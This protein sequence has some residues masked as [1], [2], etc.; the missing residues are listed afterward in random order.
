MRV[1]ILNLIVNT[2]EKGRIP[3]YDSNHD[4]MIYNM[5]R[6]FVELGH[7]V[8]LIADKAFAPL[9]EESNPFETIYLPGYA[10]CIFRPDM[11]PAPKG[12]KAYLKN[13]A[14][15]FD[16]VVS[17]ELFSMA[18]LIASRVP[19]I[20]NKL[21]VW[22]ELSV[23]Q[24]FMRQLPARFWYKVITPVL[25]GS[26]IPVIARSLPAR[27]F[28]SQFSRKVADDIVDHGV[29]AEVFVDRKVGASKSFVVVSQL[30]SRK[31][32]DRII[33]KFAR[34]LQV[35]GYQ[36]CRLD[37]IGAGDEMDNLKTLTNNLGVEHEVVFHGRLPQVQWAPISGNAVAMLIDTERDLNMVTVS[38]SIVNITPVLMNTVPATASF[39]AD[40]QLGIAREDWDIPEMIE[41][42]ERQNEF[43][44]NCRAVRES[45]TASGSAKS[46]IDIFTNRLF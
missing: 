23:Y 32:I 40:L 26:K 41:M 18:T 3:R 22:Q 31:R 5:A 42:I 44:N 38:E 36:D 1:L 6:G 9:K 30:I 45:L 37:I 21:V 39:V 19:E 16:M 17:S 28:V 25:I 10:R 2:A 12:L 35:D 14:G 46:I 43:R 27:R 34:L 13:N 8:T 20:R 15:C 11:L 4:S 29:N 33:S 7:K 24:R